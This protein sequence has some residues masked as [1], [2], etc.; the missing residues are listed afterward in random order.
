MKTIDTRAKIKQIPEQ[1][2]R[3]QIK[4][5]M[6]KRKIKLRKPNRLTKGK[7]AIAVSMGKLKE[8]IIN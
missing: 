2:Q 8:H 1:Q 6:L 5:D 7:K 3:T 4:N